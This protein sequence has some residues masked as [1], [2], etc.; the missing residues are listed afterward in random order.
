MLFK[1]QVLRPI[2]LVVLLLV[3]CGGHRYSYAKV[4]DR[5]L[6][7]CDNQALSMCAE[8][9]QFEEIVPC[10]NRESANCQQQFTV[11]RKATHERYWPD[12][13]QE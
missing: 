1:C 10:L 3:G 4:C 13:E 11:C 2:A 7:N 8:L 9:A 6:R 12:K 5:D